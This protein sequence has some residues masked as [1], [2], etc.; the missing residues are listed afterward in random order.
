MVAHGLRW[1]VH[2]LLLNKYRR[3]DCILHGLA[4]CNHR[5]LLDGVVLVRR[6]HGGRLRSVRVGGIVRHSETERLGRHEQKVG[7]SDRE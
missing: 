4:G 1:E 2:R 3:I 7:E 5:W 6:W